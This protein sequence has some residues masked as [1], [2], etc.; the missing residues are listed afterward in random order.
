MALRSPCALAIVQGMTPRE[1]ALKRWENTTPEQRS[2]LMRALAKRQHYLKP[3]RVWFEA[4]KA[5]ESR[6]LGIEAILSVNTDAGFNARLL[7]RDDD[8]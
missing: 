7:E 2:K 4:F 8:K 6:V 3:T 5:L 1:M